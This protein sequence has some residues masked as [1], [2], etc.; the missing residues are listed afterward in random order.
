MAI[1]NFH[2]FNK[3]LQKEV[4]FLAILPERQE[5]PGPTPPTTFYTA[6]RMTT[7]AWLRWSSIERHVR[8][9]PLIVILP[10]VTATGTLTTPTAR[11]TSRP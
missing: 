3:A 5:Q 9:L 4:G 6:C 7:T 2:Y 10:T 11:S 8:D 1:A